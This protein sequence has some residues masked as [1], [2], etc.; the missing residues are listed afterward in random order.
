[1]RP[2]LKIAKKYNAV[3]I[4]NMMAWKRHDLAWDVCRIAVFTYFVQ[5]NR[6]F[7]QI[8]GYRDLAF[9]NVDAQ[10]Q[11]SRRNSAEVAAL[12]QALLQAL[13]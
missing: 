12:L 4:A 13:L 11:L 6:E 10:R 7:R 3:H 2:N 5:E 1:M 9:I 8:D